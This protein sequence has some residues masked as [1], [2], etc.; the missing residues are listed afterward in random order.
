MG[1]GIGAL[2]STSGLWAGLDPARESS[3]TRFKIQL[4]YVYLG[5][6]DVG[7][8][9][10]APDS[11]SILNIDLRVAILNFA[12]A[13]S[14]D[15][16]FNWVVGRG[17]QLLLGILS[18]R[19]FA[20]ALLKAAEEHRIPV[21]VFMSLAIFSTKPDVLWQLSCNFLRATGWRVRTMIVW[22]CLSTIFLAF[23]PALMDISTGYEP[24]SLRYL[25][26]EDGNSIA[27]VTDERGNIAQQQLYQS[28][29]M[30]VTTHWNEDEKAQCRAEA[31]Y[32]DSVCDHYSTI[33]FVTNYQWKSPELQHSWDTI[34]NKSIV[35]R[36]AND[37]NNFRF[38]EA[39]RGEFPRFALNASSRYTCHVQ[40]DQ[41]VWGF[42]SPWLFATGVLLSAWLFGVW[43]LWVDADHNGQFCRKGRRMGHYRAALD[44]AAALNE[45][46]G[47]DTGAYADG[48]LY[49][50]V[51]RMPPVKYRVEEDEQ[52]M[53]GRIGLSARP[54]G[55]VKLHW[56]EKYA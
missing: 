47:P 5:S 41:F 15:L 43:V 46:F 4:N 19:V 36:Y 39:V 30:N 31:R 37:T 53:T 16:A 45:A 14:V 2:F 13:K 48:Q 25:S 44:V 34:F 42:S 51:K 21:P 26:D 20:D 33:D 28:T 27:Q 38:G 3:P 22:A 12:Q 54:S 9:Y 49:E 6:V 11:L 18:Y 23:I 50:R 40:D 24:A 55:R 56:N 8:C 17:I 7:S 52:M 35:L 29:K 32:P 1:G 10:N